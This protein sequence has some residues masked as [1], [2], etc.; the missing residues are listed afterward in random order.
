MITIL[1]QAKACH[2]KRLGDRFVRAIGNCRGVTGYAW[3]VRDALDKRYDVQQGTCDADD[4][5]EDVR[6]A[7]DAQRMY[8]PSYVE[9]PET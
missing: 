9:W 8:I 3:C 4:L 6:K 7:A 1:F 5:P 2:P